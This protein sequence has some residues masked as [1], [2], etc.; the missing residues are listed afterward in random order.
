MD[1]KHW[2]ENWRAESALF[3]LTRGDAPAAVPPAA[4]KADLFG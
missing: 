2:L 4:A 1:P 3:L